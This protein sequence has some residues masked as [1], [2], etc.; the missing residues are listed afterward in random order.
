MNKLA[1]LRA[2][3]LDAVPELKRGPER[4]LTFVQ[5]GS[6]RF[7]RG[8]HLSHEYRF[9]AQLVV[10]DYAGD[11][12]TLMIPMLQWLSRYEP[13]LDPDDGVRFEAELL[14]NQAYD[15]AITLRLS[16]R[17]VALV[18][19][20]AGTITSEHRQP[21]YPIETCPATHWELLTKAP[22]NDDYQPTS[23]W[24]SP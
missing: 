8:Q 9:E 17:V 11:V 15:L 20:E 7:Q 10:T 24:D 19:C 4:L 6:I 1:S 21:A 23:E 14:S 22:G 18:D 5:D 3:L 2:H 16:E 12:D 13:D